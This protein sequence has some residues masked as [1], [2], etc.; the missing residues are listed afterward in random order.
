MTAIS[1]TVFTAAQFN[2]CVRDNLSQTAPA[3]V[4]AAGQLIVS[5][6]A[7]LITA[8]QPV[9]DTVAAAEN[10]ISTSYTNLPTIGPAV[11][12]VTGQA[13]LVSIASTLDNSVTNS[14]SMAS[15]EVSGQTSISASDTWRIVRD[16]ANATNAWRAG[17]V[18]FQT[19]LT[20]GSNTFTMKYAAGSNSAA[21]SFRELIVIPL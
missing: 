13:A 21:F 15:Y 5:A 14:A 3:V 7:G 17:G 6:G 10:T 12:V 19:A 11:T 18:S 8:R 16:G 2:G 20:P 1:G 4:S 9:S